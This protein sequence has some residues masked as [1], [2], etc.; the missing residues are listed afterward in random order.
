M[1]QASNPGLQDSR[2]MA[3]ASNPGLQDS[4]SMAQ[5][6]NPGLQDSSSMAQA[7]NSVGQANNATT[8]S[9]TNQALKPATGMSVEPHGRVNAVMRVKLSAVLQRVLRHGEFFAELIPGVFGVRCQGST[10]LDIHMLLPNDG[11]T[12]RTTLVAVTGEPG[13][14]EIL[15]FCEGVDMLKNPFLPLPGISAEVDTIVFRQLV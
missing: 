4:S 8:T 3:Q 9:A 2:S 11:V 13:K 10:Y 5:A 7:S 14:W 12:Y 15:E 1:A 6:S